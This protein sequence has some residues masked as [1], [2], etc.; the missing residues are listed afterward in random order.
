M[1]EVNLENNKNDKVLNLTE[2]QK[3]KLCIA[4]AFIGNPK[5]VF[6]DEPTEGLDLISR[7][8]IWDFLLNK[9]KDRVIFLVTNNMEEAD[10]ITD[11]KLIISHGK[12]RC[13]GTS[14]YLKEHFNMKYSMEIESKD[15]DRINEIIKKH[16]P[17][18]YCY[19][20]NDDYQLMNTNLDIKTWKLP[21]SSSSKFSGLFNELDTLTI[22]ENKIINN[23]SLS[24]PSLE[25]LFIRLVDEYSD[26]NINPFLSE[27]SRDS[28][29]NSDDNTIFIDAYEETLDN[30]PLSNE[31]GDNDSISENSATTN[32]DDTIFVHTENDFPIYEKLDSNFKKIISIVQLR[33]NIHI[34]DIDFS[35]F[36]IIFPIIISGILHRLI[37][38]YYDNV[39]FNGFDNSSF[40]IYKY[41][42]DTIFNINSNNIN[43]PNFTKDLYMSINEFNV[44][45]YDD[46]TLNDI[47]KTNTDKQYYVSSISEL[48]ETDN[49][50]KI[51]INYNASLENALPVT[52]NAITN[53]ILASKNITE[54][55][56][57][58][59]NLANNY[60]YDNH[61]QFIYTGILIGLLSGSFVLCM[62]FFGPLII[63]ERNNQI[64]QQFQ[65]SG[66]SRKI[67][68][69]ASILG[70]SIIFSFSSFFII[71]L[72]IWRF[73]EFLF[74]FSNIFIIYLS[75]LLW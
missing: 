44:K 38:Y 30:Q 65:L 7:K 2:S 59:S 63:N 4:I 73:S 17:E 68:W 16:V 40:L 19:I 42:N 13:I 56:T 60:S 32:D 20:Q 29:T 48:L 55:I 26:D 24:I 6:L 53:T 75:N 27:D 34:N 49:N 11:R 5:Y 37:S 18:S 21:I 23:Y 61:N 51:N 69:I 35:F 64:D 15:F 9:K 46:K 47:G 72:C 70:E 41:N 33:L 28:R 62:T 58:E 22:A 57:I 71:S 3:R 45:E 43:I 8:Q 36:T 12:M 67:Y 31:R 54:K 14:L 25:E 74:S 52:L 66:I 1:K 10:I 39:T 50:Y